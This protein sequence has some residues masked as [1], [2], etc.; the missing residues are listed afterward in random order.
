MIHVTL[1][2]DEVIRIFR[3]IIF[4]SFLE[5]N[6]C[7][8]AF[9]RDVG[10]H[11]VSHSFFFFFFFFFFKY[12]PILL[13]L[14]LS[15]YAANRISQ[16]CFLQ[17]IYF[18]LTFLWSRSLTIGRFAHLSFLQGFSHQQY[19][20]KQIIFAYTFEEGISKIQFRDGILK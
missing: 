12:F 5:H 1:E 16:N 11:R 10:K 13:V 3:L 7:P 18:Y 17:T 9:A 15:F 6:R 4:L 2:L 14:S 8:L 19:L 20:E